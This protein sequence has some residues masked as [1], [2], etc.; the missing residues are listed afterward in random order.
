MK[1][2]ASVTFLLCLWL[3][4]EL[5]SAVEFS[6]EPAKVAQLR[7]LTRLELNREGPLSFGGIVTLVDSAREIFV[8]QDDTGAI[9]L[10]PDR[11]VQVRAGD[12][13]SLHVEGASPY[14]VNFPNYPFGISGTDVRTN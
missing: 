4:R 13:V 12:V 9:V 8:L 11:A 6:A 2:S 5:S 1:W 10:H 7:A 3:T 14:V